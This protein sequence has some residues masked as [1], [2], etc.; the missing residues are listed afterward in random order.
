VDIIN[1]SQSASAIENGAQLFSFAVYQ[2]QEQ[3]ALH[4]QR[5]F[6]IQWQPRNDL[7]IQIGYVGNS[8]ATWSFPCLQPGAN[9]TPLIAQMALAVPAD[10]YYGYN[11][12]SQ[13]FSQSAA[14]NPTNNAPPELF[15]HYE[16]G[17]ST[18]ASVYRLLRGIGSYSAAGISAYNACKLTSKSV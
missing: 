12:R 7:S 2:P 17:T 15:E 9:R 11:P 6:D 1:S 18:C 14:D 5:T 3:A 16:G 8:A 10:L 13:T 4:H